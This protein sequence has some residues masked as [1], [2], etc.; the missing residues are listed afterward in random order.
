MNKLLIFLLFPFVLEANSPFGFLYGESLV[1]AKKSSQSVEKSDNSSEMTERAS[2]AEGEK[3]TVSSVPDSSNPAE[4][5]TAEKSKDIETSKDIEKSDLQAT[6]APEESSKPSPVSAKEKLLEGIEDR[7]LAEEQ[8]LIESR[9]PA[10]KK[11]RKI[12]IKRDSRFKMPQAKTV[13]KKKKAP[14]DLKLI[15]PPA[16]I[17]FYYSPGSDEAELEQVM[18]EEER[19]LFKLLKERKDPDLILRLA[20]LYV[21]R[22]RLISFKIQSDYNVKLEQYKKGQRATKPYLNLKPAQVYN[23]KSLKLFEGF[24]SNYP[25]HKRMDEVLFFLGFNFYQLEN[26]KQ[27]IKYYEELVNRFP[28]SFYIYETRFQLGEHYFQLRNWQSSLRY[29]SIVSRNKTGKFYF[30][31]LYKMAWCL[32]KLNKISQGLSLLER[33][34]R[35]SGRFQQ[36]SDRSQIVTFADEAVQDLTLFYT[37]SKKSP[38]EARS[39]FI[40]LLGPDKAWPLL[41]KLAYA[42]RDTGQ[43]RALIILF[44]NLIDY[45]PSGKEAFDYKFQI[46]ESIY[47]TGR[48]SEII[49]IT[50]EWVEN[51]GPGS[52]WAIANQQ[53]R[54]LLQKA[55]KLQEVTIRNFALKN[56]QTYRKTKS[57]QSKTLAVNLYKFYFKVFTNSEFSDQMYFWY[58]EILF[59]SKQ[60]ISA[61]KA[62]EGV[63][64]KFPN[65]KY[66]K[67]SYLNQVLA[68]ER[69]LPSDKEI[70]EMVGTG[71]DPVE[72]PAVIKSFLKIADRYVSQFPRAENSPTILY[73]MAALTYRFNQY[74]LSIP[75]FKK[76]F[77]QYSGHSLAGN[78]GS[79]LLDIYSKNK[80][81]KSLEALAVQLSQT[82]KNAELLKEAR[83]ILEQ[84]SFKRAQDLALNKKYK[85]SALL[86]EKFARS[87]P[88]S[89]LAP[90]AF[91]N[92]GLNFVNAKDS[93]QA[94]SMYSSVITY[95]GKAHADIRKKSREF[96]AVLYEKLGFY[97]KAADA[98]VA[99][100][101]AYPSSEKSADFW[102]NAGV[103]FDALN[104]VGSA[105]YSYNKYYGLSKKKDRYEVYYLIAV[106]YEKNRKWANAIQYYDKFLNTPSSNALRVMMAS[107]SIADIYESRLKNSSLAKTWHQKTLNLYRR[108]KTGVS[109]G[110]RS[111][112]YIVKKD[113][114]EPFA[115]L[116]IPL[117]PKKQKTIIT[118]K[119]QLLQSLERALKPIIRYNEGET[120][121]ASLILIGQANEEFARQI[122]ASPVPKGLDKEGVKKYKAGILTVVQPY[123]KKSVEHYRLAIQRSV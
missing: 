43:K 97:K 15:E 38:Q 49:Q 123:I 63:L 106:L 80:D 50:K 58:A 35:E 71:D 44:Q 108:L 110:A 47:N 87:N 10:A 26:K 102:Y 79:I 60:Y 95:K 41:K 34:I 57:A 46:V 14:I 55:F 67:A 13:R 23:Q 33:I 96:I 56:H 66:A 68:L 40:N 111:H 121:L 2:L 18:V 27:G 22:S 91:Y 11:V 75:Y 61:V 21:D 16:S 74:D 116:K 5:K 48:V 78:V 100:A 31:S 109:Y 92:A 6:S 7:A 25:T 59:D 120:I 51:Y 30:F 104:D 85:E 53:N 77:E 117:D 122:Y 3:E 94:L 115:K 86:Y 70:R 17:P 29:Y 8:T 24:K 28:R 98:Y 64:S 1:M 36:S 45:N 65:S 9:T 4:K 90:S 119:I 103:I 72:M 76:M 101:K 69:A 12:R 54:S 107:F 19:Q 88:G 42:Y 20:S 73:K 105:I 93:L 52:T 81:Y 112:F 83:S 113:Y 89:S 39:F 82:S 99:F 84:I 114:Y 118:K 62:Y 37:Y 32:Y